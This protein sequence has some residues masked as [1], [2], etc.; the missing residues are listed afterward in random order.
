MSEPLEEPIQDTE[1]V[2][3]TDSYQPQEEQLGKKYF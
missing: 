2:D 1:P 3:P